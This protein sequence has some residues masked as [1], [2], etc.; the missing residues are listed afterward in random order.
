MVEL[1]SLVQ[2]VSPKSIPWAHPKKAPF[3]DKLWEEPCLVN[4]FKHTQ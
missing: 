3:L 1:F 4:V 2:A